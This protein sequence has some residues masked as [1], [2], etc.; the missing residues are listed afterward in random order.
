MLISANCKVLDFSTIFLTL[1]ITIFYAR[2]Q[3]EGQ[4]KMKN[5]LAISD[6]Q[7]IDNMNNSPPRLHFENKAVK[8]RL[9]NL[10]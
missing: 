4:I 1:Q 7:E 3:H 9:N 2:D 10:S 8:A 6:D 5:I